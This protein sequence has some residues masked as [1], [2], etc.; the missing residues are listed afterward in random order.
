MEK[1]QK[2]YITKYPRTLAETET[3]SRKFYKEAGF[4]ITPDTDK[5]LLTD[6][7]AFTLQNVYPYIFD[8][9]AALCSDYADKTFI[10]ENAGEKK[11]TKI[12]QG[13]DEAALTHYQAIV[14]LD[15]FKNL[16][17]NGHNEYWNF[18]EKEL[19]EMFRKP[20]KRVLPFTTGLVIATHPIEVDFIY[21][22]GIKA[23]TIKKLDNIGADRK[24]KY[25]VLRFYKPLFSSIL[26]KNRK[27][28]IGSNY[29]KM[30]RAMQA[31]INS[32]LTEL[33]SRFNHLRISCPS[34]NDNVSQFM[35]A[36]VEKYNNNPELAKEEMGLKWRYT[37]I[38]D[39]EADLENVK[40]LTAMEARKIFLFLACHDDKKSPF[41]SINT[42][43][44]AFLVGCFP[45][46]VDVR[47]SGKI[48]IKPKYKKL[49]E[50]KLHGFT[51]LCQYLANNGKLNGA[52]FLPLNYDTHNKRVEVR[53]NKALI[54]NNQPELDFR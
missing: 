6:P 27:G 45:G 32:T 13:Q 21:E 43:F 14:P 50:Q 22:N 48:Y 44:D 26:E 36:I 24:I 4:Q 49:V 38:R 52:Q 51:W 17:L 42:S 16:A 28:G 31:E 25:I 53:R 46:F 39:Y 29:L 12:I 5:N 54:Y 15:A 20:E 41:I 7:N 11:E 10:L 1:K 18:L 47:K 19:Y 2:R 8:G 35:R 30:P 23:S 33:E 40:S 9:L 34:G 37:P 3:K